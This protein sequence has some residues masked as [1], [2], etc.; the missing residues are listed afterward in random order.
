MVTRTGVTKSEFYR[1]FKNVDAC[2][3]AA[4]DDALARASRLVADAAKSE[5]HWLERIR[6]GLRAL[7]G[8]LDAEPRWARLLAVHAPIAQQAV[9]ERRQHTIS[10]LAA[11]LDELEPS[12]KIG[13]DSSRS[14]SAI[15]AELIVRGALSLIEAQMLDGDSRLLAHLE[16]ALMSFIVAPYLGVVAASV[17]QT[18]LSGTPA[19]RLPGSAQLAARTTYRTA[20]VLRAISATPRLSNR[21]VADAAGLNDEGQTSKLLARLERQGLIENVGLGFAHGE[22]NAWLLTPYGRR[23]DKAIGS[24]FAVSQ[25]LQGRRRVR[26]AA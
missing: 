18:R 14:R 26:G 4:F 17:E 9:F 7:L 15:T 20:R 16:P 22:P 8:F 25:T 2:Y 1:I 13:V 19:E 3:L 5:Q 10:T 6:V 21:D 12:E 23:I 24:N 11:V